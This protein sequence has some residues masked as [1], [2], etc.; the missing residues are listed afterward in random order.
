MA[1][2]EAINQI[3]TRIKRAGEVMFDA[4][5]VKGLDIT[6]RNQRSNQRMLTHHLQVGCNWVRKCKCY[7]CVGKDS[8]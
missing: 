5:N 8:G 2:E 6:Y 4:M 3:V 7:V 1:K